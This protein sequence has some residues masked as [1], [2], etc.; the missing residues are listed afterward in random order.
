MSCVDNKTNKSVVINLVR[1][2]EN[3]R[4]PKTA[5][6][7]DVGFDVCALEEV[8]LKHLQ[9][10]VIPTGLTLASI[11]RT[12]LLTESV[13]D[14]SN[15][16]L[17]FKVESRSGLAKQG[18]ISLGGIIDPSYRGEIMVVLMSLTKDHI[19]KSG[20]RI[21]Q[22]VVYHVENSSNVEFKE[23]STVVTQTN[24]NTKGFGSTG[25]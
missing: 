15:C 20:D 4:F 8:E 7:G 22:F 2:N 24:R 10:T 6:E 3:A 23:A 13:D 25:T 11:Q 16:G 17:F 21:A 18:V 9:P 19:I 1:T 5:Y 12:T 14:H